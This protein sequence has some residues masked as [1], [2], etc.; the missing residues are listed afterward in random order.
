VRYLEQGNI[1]LVM[2]AP[3][4]MEA[5]RERALLRQNAPHL[6]VRHGRVVHTAILG[7]RDQADPSDN[8]VLTFLAHNMLELQQVA[9]GVGLGAWSAIAKVHELASA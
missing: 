3:L 1:A 8:S 9:S 4:V 2:E 7:C 5:L 6:S